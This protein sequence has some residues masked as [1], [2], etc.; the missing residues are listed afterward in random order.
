MSLIRVSVIFSDIQIG[1]RR[2]LH[3]Q[4]FWIFY[5]EIVSRDSIHNFEEICFYFDQNFININFYLSVHFRNIK[6]YGLVAVGT[7]TESTVPTNTVQ[8]PITTGTVTDRG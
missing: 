4:L 2:R 1:N 7:G 3:H 5:K 8:V 6:N